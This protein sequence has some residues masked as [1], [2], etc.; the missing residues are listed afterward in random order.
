MAWEA[1][2]GTQ[3]STSASVNQT[4]YGDSSSTVNLNPGESC[5]VTVDS[6]TNGTTDDLIVGVFY[7]N[8]GTNWDDDPNRSFLV[9]KDTDPHQKSIIVSGPPHFKLMYKGTGSTDTFTVQAYARK[10]GVSA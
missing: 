2:P 5:L 3:I 4:T 9:D 7:S 1:S 10:D 8:D 6:D